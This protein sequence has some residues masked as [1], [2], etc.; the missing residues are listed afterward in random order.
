MNLE[1]IESTD[2]IT[3]IKLIGRLDIAGI[4]QVQLKFLGHTAAR[5]LPTVVDMSEVSFLASLGIRMFVDA[6]KNI[7]AAGGHLVLL[8]PQAHVE[9]SITASGLHAIMAICHNLEE[10]KSRA[11]GKSA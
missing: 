10:A 8:S 5:K 3:V 7:R 2:S 6:A 11:L 1:V 9:K 4:D